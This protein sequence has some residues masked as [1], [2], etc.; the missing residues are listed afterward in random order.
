MRIA[1]IILDI[2]DDPKGL[3]LR[4]KL[5]RSGEELPEK[6]ASSQVLDHEEL[7]QLP[8][9]LFA[10]VAANNGQ[11]LRKFAMHDEAHLA[12]SILYFLERGHVLPEEAQKTAAQ[13]LVNACA[14]YDMDPPEP[15]VKVAL[16]DKLMTGAGALMSAADMAGRASSA[17]ARHRQT[18]NAFRAAQTVGA[19]VAGRTIDAANLTG[20]VASGDD[21]LAL[22]TAKKMSDP[23][24]AARRVNAD[25]GFPVLGGEK[26]ANLVGTDIMPQ[27]ALTRPVRNAPMRGGVPMKTA[28]QHLASRL[29]SRWQDC[30]DLSSMEA[31]AMRKAARYEHFALPHEKR[32]P[33][34]TE[35]QIKQAAAYFDDY[36]TEMALLDRRIYAR[37]V[38]DRADDLGTKVAGAILE[39][40]GQGY[41]DFIGSELVARERGFEGTGHDA[42]YALLR[43][44]IA[45]IPP[46]LMAELLFEA[47]KISG[48]QN[49]YGR[50]GTGFR[51][52]YASVYAKT[53]AKETEYSWKSGTDYVSGQALH[54]LARKG[55]EVFSSSFGVDFGRG[56]VKDPVGIFSSL[57]EPEKIVIARMASSADS[58]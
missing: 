40:A 11:L 53:A 42:A 39:Y 2:Y 28:A 30:G 41:G 34:D 29:D 51:D 32:Y 36:Y 56:F 21:G 45:E 1:G 16:F 18:M 23:T 9:R 22:G 31:P 38:A 26:A 3:V 17:A 15:L 7:D 13:N 27:G 47:D 35:A 6:L 25:V 46:T 57:P 14:W 37:S 5:A 48:A 33:I 44:K 19:K 49:S 24:E 12:T 58:G 54:D 8:D 10:L 4:E 20:D 50:P 43:E 55:P 52:P